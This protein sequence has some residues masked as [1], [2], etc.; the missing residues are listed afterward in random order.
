MKALLTPKGLQKLPWILFITILNGKSEP[1]GFSALWRPADLE[2][3]QIARL[4]KL[5]L[6]ITRRCLLGRFGS[7]S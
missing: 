4:L 5:Y 7:A 1:L 3:F 2:S 6:V